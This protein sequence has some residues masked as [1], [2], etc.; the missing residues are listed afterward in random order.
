MF[1]LMCKEV[2]NSPNTCLEWISSQNQEEIHAT[3]ANISVIVLF[4]GRL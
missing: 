3:L 4:V 2:E 1:V